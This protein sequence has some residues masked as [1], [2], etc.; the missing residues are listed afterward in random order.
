M[1]YLNK[2]IMKYTKGTV[3][4]FSL[5]LLVIWSV[6]TPLRAQGKFDAD[7]LAEKSAQEYAEEQNKDL[8]SYLD[9]DIVQY[10]SHKGGCSLKSSLFYS[11]AAQYKKG[12]SVSEAAE[13]PM[14]EPVIKEVY[15]IIRKDG[16]ERATLRNMKEYQD[17]VANAPPHKNA[18]REY[19]LSLK[20]NAC[21]EL[22]KILLDTLDHI[23]GRK[24]ARRLVDKYVR[25]SPD[26]IGTS[27]EDINDPVIFFIGRLYK[28][29][30]TKDYKDIVQTA[31]SII[32][33]CYS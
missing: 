3:L 7:A 31:S 27:Y 9:D 10:P 11:V 16:L 5:L 14:Y 28:E 25:N 29:A 2:Y 8:F 18:S 17:C 22:S 26:F 4:L 15:D 1:R 33:G 23:K 30:K 12:L 6:P 21:G 20:N 24:S 13:A 19:D 32:T